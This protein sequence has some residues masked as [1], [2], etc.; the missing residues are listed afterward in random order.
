VGANDAGV[1]FSSFDVGEE[2][3]VGEGVGFLAEAGEFGPDVGAVAEARAAGA[4]GARFGVGESVK[5]GG[6]GGGAG[7]EAVDE[8]AVA[9]GER[10]GG[11]MI[12]D[13]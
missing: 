1:E 4:G 3:G 5:V 12:F 8:F 9:L 10:H 13:F 11:L 2:I 6:F 7:E